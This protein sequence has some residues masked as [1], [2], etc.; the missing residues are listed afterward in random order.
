MRL[1][2]VLLPVCC[3]GLKVLATSLIL[4][5]GSFEGHL[6][7]SVTIGLCPVNI[8]RLK[9]QLPVDQYCLVDINWMDDVFARTICTFP[10]AYLMLR[11]LLEE[12]C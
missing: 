11:W 12:A 6:S 10:I 1:L 3:C 8:S 2:T 4:F 5:H 7:S 9:N